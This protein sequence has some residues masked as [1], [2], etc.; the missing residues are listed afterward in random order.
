M[1]EVKLNLARKW[2]SKQFNQIIGQ[3]L[4]VR[5]LKNSLYLQQYFPVYLFSGQRGCGKTSTARV[6][7]A[8]INCERLASFQKDPKNKIVPCLECASCKAMEAGK[9]PDFIEIDAASHTGV[10]HVRMLID[11]A[12]LLPLM[13]HKKIYLIDEA[14]ML[15]KAAFNALLKILE[16]PPSSAVFILAT[17]DPQKIIDTVRSRCFQLFFRPVGIELLQTRLS[18]VCT[19]EQ[20]SY[21]DAG[22]LLIIKHTDGSVRDALNLLE[23][24]RY[25]H[26]AITHQAVSE[27]LGFI[28]DSA[29]ITLLSNVITA[30][31][32]GILKH[33]RAIEWQRFSP[34]IIWVR[35]LELI[36]AA[37]WIKYNIEPEAF[38]EYVDEIKNIIFNCNPHQL[39]FFL[40]TMYDNELLF[41]KT[42]S[43]HEFIEML[44]LKL[45][46]SLNSSEN[47]GGASPSSI[48]PPSATLGEQEDLDE[49]C[50]N[51]GLEDDETIIARWKRFVEKVAALNDP[52][53][54][55]IFVQGEPQKVMLDELLIE[56]Q[57]SKDLLFF[58][59]LLQ[60]TQSDWRPFL[61]EVFGA[62][63]AIK[64]SYT[65]DSRKINISPVKI[66]LGAG[67]KK[68][69]K[70]NLPPK[71]EKRFVK[72]SGTILPKQ[73]DR[74]VLF[75]DEQSIDISDKN[76]WKKANMVLDYFPGN[77]TEIRE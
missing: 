35:L 8:S 46:G 9:H 14:H 60:Q 51:Q 38:T 43:K 11:S 71:S 29:L 40:Q 21:D 2:R 44:L 34:H 25:A 28:D 45:C 20:I 16:D 50:D 18:D 33:I 39:T 15:S 74:S 23:Q 68:E 36:R 70:S 69:Q 7:A 65:G 30:D 55:S 5:M 73:R 66:E 49:D 27:V 76:L 67:K 64:A 63:F 54:V 75:S 57:F 12:S 59:D 58:E 47:S 72:K 31:V 56:V 41:T 42:T 1:S 22:L 4:S 13:G 37:L 48:V 61:Q 62:G 17:T 3:D 52:L 53:L 32:V 6:F 77:I 26:S 10:D 24:V 19:H